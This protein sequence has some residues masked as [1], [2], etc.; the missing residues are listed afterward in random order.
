MHD[1]AT[2]DVLAAHALADSV[3]VD[4]AVQAAKRVHLSGALRDM[5]P[6]ERGRLVQD[7]GRYLLEHKDEIAR[8]LTFEQ[9]KPFWEAIIEVE[10]AAL[11]FNITAIRQVPLR[12]APFRW[13]RA[14][15]TGQSM[16][17]LASPPRS[18]RGTTRL[19]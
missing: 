15:S 4:R 9:G 7:M 12:V 18:S 10:G 19:R 2:G 16:S 8:V 5:R 11:Y 13:V 3:D 14:I 6:I 1:P 17:R